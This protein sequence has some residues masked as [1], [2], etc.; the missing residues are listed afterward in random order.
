MFVRKIDRPKE[1][2]QSL[3]YRKTDVKIPIR[4]DCCIGFKS[5]ADIIHDSETISLKSLSTN[6]YDEAENDS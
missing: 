1:K 5:F 4:I 3:N 2:R 6:N